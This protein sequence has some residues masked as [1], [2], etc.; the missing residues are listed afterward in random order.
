MGVEK[1]TKVKA[2]HCLGMARSSRQR[3]R[4]PSKLPIHSLPT[5]CLFCHLSVHPSRCQGMPAMLC[6]CTHCSVEPALREVGWK[7]KGMW[8]RELKE[9]SGKV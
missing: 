1:Y 8:D 6:R 4:S 2:R 7:K 9:E 5:T 3:G